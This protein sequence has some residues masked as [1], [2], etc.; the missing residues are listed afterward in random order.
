MAG[1]LAGLRV[2]DLARG[3]PGPVAAL[4]LAEAGAEV[5][6][7]EPPDGDLERGQA[8]FATWNRGKKSMI[9]DLGTGSGRTDLHRLLASVD[10]LI[11]DLEPDAAQSMGLSAA[12]CAERYPDLVVAAVT[13]WPRSHPDRHLPAR[14]TLVLARLG[15]MDEQPGHR[16]GPIFIRLPFASWMTA[17]LCTIGILA[18][19]IHRARGG[20]GGSANTSLAQGAL[21]PMTMHWARA[22][23]PSQSF[24]AG[25]SKSVAVAIHQCSDGR[26]IHVHYSPDK[27]PLM[28]EAL[29]A[30]G[31]DGVV[32]ANARWGKNHTA[33]NFGANK[34][35]IATRPSRVWLEHFWAHDIAAQPAAGLGAIYFDAQAR[36]NG[37]V[38]ETHDPIFGAM[39]QP[40]PPYALGGDAGSVM[41]SIEVK[42]AR[43]HAKT[44][45]RGP[46]A[47]L[48]VLD[49]GAY[50]AGPFGAM[51]LADLGA[52][53]IKVEPVGGEAMRYIERGF[54]G[55]QR[56]KRSLA[57]QLDDPRSRP[58]LDALLR[59]AD[60]VHHNLRMPAARKLGLDSPALSKVNPGL[61]AC[62]VSSYGPKGPRAD[63]PGFDQMFQSS[64]GWEVENGGEGNQPMWLRF[65][66]TDHFGAATSLIGL[67]LAVYHRDRTGAAIPVAASLLGG[68]IW[69]TSEVAVHSD[70][71]LE[72][73]PRLDR[74]QTGVSDEHRIYRCADGWIAVAA[75][76]RS[77]IAAF[78]K[79][80]EPSAVDYFQMLSVAAASSALAL[81][82]VPAE[83]VRLDQCAAFLN[84]P[85]NWQAKLV[86]SYE[87]PVYGQ[88]EQIGAFWDFGDLPLSL[89][90][91]PPTI[92][93]HSR[94][95]LAE[96]GFTASEIGE[97]E[98]AGITVTSLQTGIDPSRNKRRSE[99][100]KPAP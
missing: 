65:G 79:L 33:P 57:L 98:Q 93:Q 60:V 3:I 39:L 45:G 23:R 15:L 29:A 19:L 41:G 5:I 21:A 77:E 80:C 28:A 9:L 70:G 73:Y 59:W 81:A 87:H 51:L 96:L 16:P 8:G 86:V 61:I 94:E 76:G 89:E 27:A 11:H 13:G 58:V 95:I 92:G 75:L 63:W 68:T 62:H 31:P 34:E 4:Q 88:L 85:D 1:T 37:Y 43:A 66:I 35:I 12:D 47:G 18:R 10:V 7:V 54:C 78:R 82:G 55:A 90:R 2:V 64:C 69:C 67:L 38:V 25:L 99:P 53:V 6:K 40:G 74:A 97:M 14:E 84:S 49:F 56:G 44:P 17:W 32:A 100:P 91:P 46:L 24:A 48:N 20:R 52:N 22:S 30:L 50:L 71:R 26:W 42:S 72:P 36:L 83:E